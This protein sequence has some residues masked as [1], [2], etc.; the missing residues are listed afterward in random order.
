MPPVLQPGDFVRI[1]FLLE[2]LSFP[3]GWVSYG[4]VSEHCTRDPDLAVIDT[5]KGEHF[6]L[7][8]FGEYELEVLLTRTDHEKVWAYEQVQA[9]IAKLRQQLED[10]G[11]D[12]DAL[13]ADH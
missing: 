7:S 4:V 5:D 13:L 10:Q 9:D 8:R 3:A 1:Q 11:V 12:V 6:V 2:H